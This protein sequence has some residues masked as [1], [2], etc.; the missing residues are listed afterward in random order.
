MMHLLYTFL[1]YLIQP[2]V[3]LRL[4][5]RGRKAP[6][7][8]KRWAERYG[9]CQGK[10]V[11]GGILLHSVSV[12]E[13][14]AAIPLVKALQQRYPELPITITTMTPTG[15]ERVKATF[16][17]QVSHVYLPY[18]LP[19]AI[20]HFLNELQP[21][22]V[23]IMETELWPNLINALSQRHIPLIVANARLSARSARGYK[24]LGKMTSRLMQKVSLIAAQ[25][26]QDG[27]RFVSLGLPEKQLEI[28]GSIKF[29]ISVNNDLKME[30][31][32]LRKS[33]GNNRLIWIAASTHEGEEDAILESYQQ[34]LPLYPNLLLVLVP[35]HPERFSDVENLIKRE[36]L[37]YVRRSERTLPTAHTQV[38]LGDTMGE[39]MLLYGI[40]DIAFVGGSLVERGGHNPLE[41]A[42]YGL[43]IV[44]GTHVFNFKTICQD[45][46][47]A[48][49]L[50]FVINEVMLT[51]AIERLCRDESQRHLQGQKALAVLLRNQ[52]ALDKLLNL[53]ESL[54]H[55]KS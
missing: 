40:A 14:I 36:G 46:S 53:I 21:K 8:R 9:F 34:L 12:G 23:I 26:P 27:A 38:V 6:A 2:L 50:T 29:D 31:Q 22:I 16:K 55:I 49:G 37:S 19:C 52:G 54:L 39:M 10:V 15:S 11:P 51:E 33:W 25:N 24:K 3:W 7:Y 1:F 30:A 45:L 47:V 17:E 4:F 48:G 35:R 18:D 20:N 43:P 42:V 44:M 13:T 5:L 41:P 28:T 32:Q